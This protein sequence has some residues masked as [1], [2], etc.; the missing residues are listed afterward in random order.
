MK[1]VNLWIWKKKTSNDMHF[2]QIY[3]INW[4]ILKI[5]SKK[6]PPTKFNN[7]HPKNYCLFLIKIAVKWIYTYIIIYMFCLTVVFDL[8]FW[9]EKPLSV[10]MNL[11]RPIRQFY[12]FYLLF[13][14]LYYELY[15]SFHYCTKKIIIK[16]PQMGKSTEKLW[17]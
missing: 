12:G 17:N 13:L 4:C 16:T 9:N 6:K 7:S 2:T 3:T 11:I 1:W 8:S 10:C 15:S 14:V 5:E